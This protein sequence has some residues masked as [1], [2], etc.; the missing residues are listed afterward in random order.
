[1]PVAGRGDNNMK[2][3]NICFYWRVFSKKT[4]NG[5]LFA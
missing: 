5:M 3:L 2:S 1:M 4:I